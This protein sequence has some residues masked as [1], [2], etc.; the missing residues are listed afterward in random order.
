MAEDWLRRPVDVEDP[1]V[2]AHRQDGV[3]G[4]LRKSSETVL[5]FAEGFSGEPPLAPDLRFPQLPLDDRG[6]PRDR[7]LRDAIVRAGLDG[8]DGRGLSDRV[9][10]DQ[11][12]KV[13]VSRLNDRESREGAEPVELVVGEHALEALGPQAGSQPPR[14]GDPL[15]R[16]IVAAAAQLIEGSLRVCRG[17]VHEQYLQ[18]RHWGGSEIRNYRTMCGETLV[19]PGP[20]DRSG[21]DAYSFAFCRIERRTVVAPFKMNCTPITTVTRPITFATTRCPVFP[22]LP[23]IAGAARRMAR[24]TRMLAASAAAS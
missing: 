21:P 10:D 6:E 8:A 3:G 14:G 23:T 18:G 11:E 12:G 15:E 4:G 17:V 1:A 19:L 7:I 24:V 13:G 5:A 16:R 22:I 9:R 2:V 20:L